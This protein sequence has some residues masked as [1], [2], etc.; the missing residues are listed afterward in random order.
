MAL[1]AVCEDPYMDLYSSS[2]ETRVGRD[3]VKMKYFSVSSTFNFLEPVFG[4][5]TAKYSFRRVI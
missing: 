4:F 2:L 1:A 5:G 3:A